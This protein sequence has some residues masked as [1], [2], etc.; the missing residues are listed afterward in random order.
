LPLD[1]RVRVGSD[2]GRPVVLS[3]PDSPVGQAMEQVARSLAAT[4]SVRAFQQG[5]VIPL[6][7]ID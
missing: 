7:M 4:L 6:S 2:G 5:N 3:D 1:P